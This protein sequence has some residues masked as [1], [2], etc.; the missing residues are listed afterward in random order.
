MLRLFLPEICIHCGAHCD[1]PNEKQIPLAKYL[2]EV[3]L[4]QFELLEPPLQN[5]LFPKSSLLRELPYEIKIGSAFSFQNEGIIQSL[6]H[7]FK[8]LEMPKLASVLGSAC[9]E[10]NAEITNDYDYLLPVP[11][12]RTR[13]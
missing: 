4:R 11:L 8:Y 6:I 7:H 13:Y 9:C 12:H 2:C 3:C 1:N 10:K 5:D